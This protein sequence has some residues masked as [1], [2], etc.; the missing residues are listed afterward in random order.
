MGMV[1]VVDFPGEGERGDDGE[2]AQDEDERGDCA[3]HEA[4]PRPRPASRV[5][6]PNTLQITKSLK[7][8]FV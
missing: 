6:V 5:R 1:T 2:A 4:F 7:H 8:G 3:N